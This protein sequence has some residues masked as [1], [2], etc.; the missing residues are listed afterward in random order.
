MHSRLPTPLL[1][2][3]RRHIFLK[4]TS[5]LNLV[6]N[7]V[8]DIVVPHA[9]LSQTISV[10][11]G[12]LFRVFCVTRLDRKVLENEECFSMI[13]LWSIYVCSLFVGEKPHQCKTCGKRFTQRSNLFRHINI[14]IGDQRYACPI[15]G[16][17]FTD[18][19]AM[20]RHKRLHSIAKPR[21]QFSCQTCSAQLSSKNSLRAHNVYL[22]G[23]K[24]ANQC[25]FCK[26]FH[27]SPSK[28]ILH[29]NNHHQV[30]TLSVNSG[31]S[32]KSSISE[33]N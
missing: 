1:Q 14:H 27:V 18:P 6:S 4:W 25:R 9:L 11:D 33:V 29:L 12:F 8:S 28:L 13:S 10:P 26:T 19:S 32:S 21:K 31:V 24:T 15:C 7:L 17:K 2:L 23:L 16:R 3:W 22:H 20:A 5:Q 30:T